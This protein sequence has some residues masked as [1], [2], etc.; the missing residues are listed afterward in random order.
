MLL[1]MATGGASAQDSEARWW[2]VIPGFGHQ[3]KPRRASDEDPRRRAEVLDDLRPD[4]TPLRSDVMIEA[5]EGAVQR[6]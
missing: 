3:E 2:E 6:Y 5:L 4:A 1:F